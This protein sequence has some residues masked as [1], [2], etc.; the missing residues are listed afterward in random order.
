ME[1]PVQPEIEVET[2]PLRIRRQIVDG[3]PHSS[4]TPGGRLVDEKICDIIRMTVATVGI[5]LESEGCP[6]QYTS[7]MR[8][9]VLRMLGVKERRG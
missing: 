9:R 7:R 4:D 1:H 6:S 2:V 3:L 5:V 8:E